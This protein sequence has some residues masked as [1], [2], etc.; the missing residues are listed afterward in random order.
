MTAPTVRSDVLK[1][2]A[3]PSPLPRCQLRKKEIVLPW[4]ISAIYEASLLRKCCL[5]FDRLYGTLTNRSR[6]AD[7]RAESTSIDVDYV[8]HLLPQQPREDRR[9]R[10]GRPGPPSR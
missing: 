8:L 10:V 3:P 6:G 2:P 4:N 5:G 9:P 1:S 7:C